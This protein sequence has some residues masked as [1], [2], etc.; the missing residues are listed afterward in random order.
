MLDEYLE[1]DVVMLI[2]IVDIL[3]CL[4]CKF[5]KYKV[6]WD[7]FFQMDVVFI[8]YFNRKFVDMD[9]NFGSVYQYWVIIILGIEESELLFVV[10][11]IYGS[12]Y[13]GDGII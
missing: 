12:G 10:I 5:L 7:F 2:F 9:L 6:V 11:Y 13:C 3:F 4:Q 8:L 1:I